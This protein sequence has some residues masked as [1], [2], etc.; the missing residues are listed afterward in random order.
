M[1]LI[2]TFTSEGFQVPRYNVVTS[3]KALIINPKTDP[4]KCWLVFLSLPGKNLVFHN[5]T[6]ITIEGQQHLQIH[7]SQLAEHKPFLIPGTILST[8]ATI[9]LKIKSQSDYLF[10]F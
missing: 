9:P 8:N 2:Q 1:D 3:N 10:I 5:Q 6:T 4:P 7:D